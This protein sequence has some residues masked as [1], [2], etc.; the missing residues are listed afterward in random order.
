ML[1][2]GVDGVAGGAGVVCN[3][4]ALLAH[5]AV[6]ERRL[7][8]VGAADDGDVDGVV[9]LGLVEVG[10][11]GRH[12]VVEHVAGAVAVDGAH[13]V[14]VAQAQA[15][16]LPQGAFVAGVVELVDRQEDGGL[17]A[18]EHAGDALVFL[19]HAGAAVNEEDDG[20]GLVAGGES[21]R[22]DGLLEAVCVADGD[23]AGVDEHEV[24]AVPVGLVVG[25]VAGDAAH[26]VHDGVCSLADAVDESGLAHVGAAHDG[27]D[28]QGH[29]G[30]SFLGYAV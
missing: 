5:Q 26:L 17:G 27:N 13:G 12:D 6:G 25:A 23:A 10:R 14:R 7:A 28:W 4:G 20:V 3:D 24:G 1:D 9:F 19:G 16:E 29:E 15:V 22:G 2:H 11:Q 8:R 30:S 18:L 21:L